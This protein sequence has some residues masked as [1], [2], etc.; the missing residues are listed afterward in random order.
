MS[1]IYA[2]YGESERLSA[3][4]A[5]LVQAVSVK[6]NTVKAERLYVTDDIERIVFADGTTFV[7]EKVNR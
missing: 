3:E 6:P 2:M 4:E 7:R 1:C 5:M